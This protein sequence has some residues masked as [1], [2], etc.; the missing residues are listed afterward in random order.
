MILIDEKLQESIHQAFEK[1][2]GH[3]S[4]LGDLFFNGTTHWVYLYE[5]R[6]EENEETR[7]RK[8]WYNATIPKP[9]EERIADTI[10]ALE[11]TDVSNNPTKEE[12]LKLA[13]GIVKKHCVENS[14]S[15]S[16]RETC[17]QYQVEGKYPSEP[18]LV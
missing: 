13:I 11:G 16:V 17:L 7:R 18:K 8:I 12:A 5:P 15:D 14:M 9:W 3:E 4:L 10:Q 6:T 1:K 2:F